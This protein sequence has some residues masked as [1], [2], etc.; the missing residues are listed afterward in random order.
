MKTTTKKAEQIEY[1]LIIALYYVTGSAFS[2]VNYS[3]QIIVFFLLTFALTVFLGCTK[4]FA[5]LGTLSLCAVQ[6]LL[7]L[8]V[9]AFNE[10]GL[11]SYLAIFLQLMIGLFCASIIPL[12]RF[13]EKF[14][15]VIT[16]FAFISLAMFGISILYPQIAL[17]FPKTI[18]EASVDYYNAG[19]YVFMQPKGYTSFF[20]TARNAGVCW[21]PGC[22][23]AFLNVGLFFLLEKQRE[24]PQKQ[25]SVKFVVLVLTIISTLSTN[26]IIILLLILLFHVSVWSKTVLRH[27]T[28]IL[29]GVIGVVVFLFLLRNTDLMTSIV[30]KFTNEFSEDMGFLDRI[31][32]DRIQYL[33]SDGKFWFFGMSF[34]KWVA[35]DLS[36]WNSIIHSFLCLGIPFTVIQL[37][38]YWKGAKA[39]AKNHILLF[40][41]LMMCFST[42]TLFWRVFFDT[43]AF[44]GLVEG[45]KK[46]VKKQA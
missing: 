10:D 41:I 18:G 26:G 33:F 16:V 24:A 37:T 34:P 32:L 42:E 27:G 20:L 45:Q 38:L 3:M 40:I 6:L 19:V 2:H 17:W 4:R 43:I 23:Q 25:F 31:S 5:S 46:T 30:S 9:P 22:Y 44:Y 35:K 8:L 21:E 7:L 11:S 12:E 28:G 1:L 29:A 14:I 39:C 15:N 13:K 36:L